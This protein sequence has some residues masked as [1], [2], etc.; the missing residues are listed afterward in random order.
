MAR[1]DFAGFKVIRTTQVNG[2]QNTYSGRW[3][4][5]QTWLQRGTFIAQR[6]TL[7]ALGLWRYP[8]G[9]KA[10]KILLPFKSGFV[11][12]YG[13]TVSVAPSP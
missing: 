11:N 1:A 2:W 8:A 5:V 6:T 10:S 9:G 7:A 4:Y 3:L 12:I 13:V